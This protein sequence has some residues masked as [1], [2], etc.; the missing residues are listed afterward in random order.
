[1]RI[2]GMAIATLAVALSMAMMVGCDSGKKE[3]TTSAPAQTSTPATSEQK[4]TKLK[5]AH[6]NPTTSAV[7][8]LGHDPFAKLIEEKTK[9]KIKIEMYPAATLGKPGDQYE[10]VKSGIADIAWGFTGF[11]PGRFP[12]T[13]VMTLPMLGIDT[14]DMGTKIL[15]DLYKN[16]EYLKSEYPGVKVLALHT[17][18]GSPISSKKPINSIKDLAG[19]KIR[20]P[21]GPPLAMAQAL[22]ASP[23]VIP[24]PEIYQAA[25][26]GVI[27]AVV[28]SWEGQ[29]MLNI[30]EV[31]KNMLDCDYFV[32][33]WWIV[34]NEDSW[35]GLSPEAQKGLEEASAE[36]EK[37]FASVY[38][39]SKK[40]F[41]EKFQ[42][43]GVTINKLSPEE[44]A[45]WQEK[46]KGVWEGWTKDMEAKN[47]PGKA[48][49]AETLKLVEKYKAAK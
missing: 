32:G 6:Y 7:H 33:V 43:A 21:G 14:A 27:N 13:D 3:A 48:V 9:G 34:M 24:A 15:W 23:M 18:D 35:K 28:I 11:S 25:E 1:M 19:L 5:Y 16:T 46:A 31:Y 42:K 29:D 26:K 36:A 47:L 38:D 8:K 17:H 45:I 49:L 2:K 44:K 40:S 10:M 12:M 4:V 41:V 37:I 20:T 39:G 22:G 30:Q